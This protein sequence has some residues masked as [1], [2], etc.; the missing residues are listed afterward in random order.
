MDTSAPDLSPVNFDVPPLMPAGTP[1]GDPIEVGALAAA[2]GH[3]AGGS[4]LSLASVKSCYGHTEGTAGITGLLLALGASQQRLL[5]PVVSLRGMNPYVAAALGGFS[6]S[7]GSG[8]SGVAVPRQAAADGS[9]SSGQAAGTSS[10]GMSGVNAHALLS[11]AA[12]APSAADAH[13]PLPWQTVRH[14]PIPQQHRLLQLPRLAAPS[15]ARFAAIL[16]GTPALHFCW[17]HIIYG[18]PLLAGAVALEM[19]GAAAAMLAEGASPAPPA[20]VADAAFVAPCLLPALGS[21]RPLVLEAAVDSLSGGLAVQAAAGASLTTILTARASEL[22][23]GPTQAAADRSAGAADGSSLRALVLGSCVTAAAE[24]PSAVSCARICAPGHDA[25]AAYHQHPATGDACLHVSALVSQ[26]LDGHVATSARI[27][28]AAGLCASRTGAPSSVA[29][30][31]SAGGW[32]A[33]KVRRHLWVGW[34]VGLPC[35]AGQRIW[36]SRAR[37]LQPASLFAQRL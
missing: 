3:P 29:S 12:G 22:A 7:G 23:S 27:P 4:K 8:G 14:W 37:H 35:L 28:V 36:R 5:P 15:S 2:L 30:G 11:P 34:A 24:G 31:G 20:A 10:F 26:M 32:A 25:T 16:T 33:V 18:R 6:S 1:L 17:E 21:G 9:S 19:A 13:K